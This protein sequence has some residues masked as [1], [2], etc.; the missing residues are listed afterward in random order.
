MKPST[1]LAAFYG[2]IAVLVLVAAGSW[3]ASRA[4]QGPKALLRAAQALIPAAR[5]HSGIMPI[6]MKDGSIIKVRMTLPVGAKDPIF[7]LVGK[8][9]KEIPYPW[10]TNPAHMSLPAYMHK[11]PTPE[12][13]ALQAMVQSSDANQQR[14]YQS[15]H[16]LDDRDKAA[17]ASAEGVT[18]DHLDDAGGTAL[19]GY[20]LEGER[21]RAAPK[22]DEGAI[23]GTYSMD[24]HLLSSVVVKDSELKSPFPTT[25]SERDASNIVLRR[26]GQGLLNI[27]VWIRGENGQ[28]DK[29]HGY[30]LPWYGPSFRPC[31]EGR[32]DDTGCP[33]TRNGTAP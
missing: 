22:D 6:T 18:A 25:F 8:D 5:V 21:M 16:A 24:G 31:F 13:E 12:Q 26:T 9:G 20:L 1:R 2:L 27:T 10:D 30:T 19:I 4:P 17:M 14:L 23:Q 3:R 28:P 33:E 15:I 29:A 11:P 32:T 7:F